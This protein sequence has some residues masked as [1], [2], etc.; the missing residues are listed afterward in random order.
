MS[1]CDVGVNLGSADVGMAKERLD[2]AEIGTIHEK[3]GGERVA[4]SVRSDMLGNA[5]E[6]GVFFNHALDTAWG[7]A[8]EIAVL[9]RGAG[10]FRIIKEEGRKLVAPSV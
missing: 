8:A 1:V 7:E 6:A 2:R 5:G 3:V 9:T 4:E 10:I